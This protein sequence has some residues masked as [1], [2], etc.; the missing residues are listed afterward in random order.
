MFKS[1][2]LVIKILL[3]T[4]Q[5]NSSKKKKR[6]IN[7]DAQKDNTTDLKEDLSTLYPF[8]KTEPKSPETSG[9][10]KSPEMVNS[11]KT[12]AS[13]L[14]IKTESKLPASS[15]AGGKRKSAEMDDSKE[16]S[17]GKK[18]RKT[19]NH[20]VNYRGCSGSDSDED[21]VIDGRT[22]D[23]DF[24][25]KKYVDL[26]EKLTASESNLTKAYDSN[27]K[28]R[29]SLAQVES[30]NLFLEEK[31]KNLEQE[32]EKAKQ[33]KDDFILIVC[34][35]CSLACKFTVTCQTV[36]LTVFLSV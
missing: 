7:R 24:T 19:R 20:F 8:I 32:L 2:T 9:G 35:V 6:G 27:K 34:C 28:L 12:S 33:G 13:C 1:A 17:A 18:P 21:I 3:S 36:L 29:V 23:P 11:K 22:L 14:L 15:G 16:T 5:A 10:K 31:V 30:Q 4:S 25:P 26:Q